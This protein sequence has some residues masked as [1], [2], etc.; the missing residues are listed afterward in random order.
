MSRDIYVCLVAEHQPIHRPQYFLPLFC[1]GR[2]NTSFVRSVSSRV[3]VPLV[4]T[5]SKN[6]AMGIGGCLG[7]YIGDKYFHPQ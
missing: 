3:F 1:L 7:M 5:P 2:N 4:N 6:K